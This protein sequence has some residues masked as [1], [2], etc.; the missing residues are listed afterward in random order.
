MYRDREFSGPSLRALR[1]AAGL[2]QE[3][4]ALLIGRGAP[5]IVSLETGHANPSLKTLTR[6]VDA[7]GC[8]I[9]DLLEPTVD[10]VGV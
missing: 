3:E 5:M 10:P 8:E 4:L 1:L 7:L 9:D 2:Q 6:L